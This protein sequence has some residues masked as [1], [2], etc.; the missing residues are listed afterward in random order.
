MTVTSKGNH[1]E[2]M[3]AF[4]HAL[5]SARPARLIIRQELADYFGA[6]PRLVRE[7]ERDKE[8]AQLRKTLN[9]TTGPR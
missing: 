4:G 5:R 6:K 1:L 8:N 2:T 7:L 3:K 9:L